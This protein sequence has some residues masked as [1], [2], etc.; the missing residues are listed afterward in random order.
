[1][2]LKRQQ[3][4]EKTTLLAYNSSC[5]LFSIAANSSVSLVTLLLLGASISSGSIF[6]V[7]GFFSFFL[8]LIPCSNM[9]DIRDDNKDKFDSVLHKLLM[10]LPDFLKF[11]KILS[12][13]KSVSDLSCAIELRTEFWS[14]EFFLRFLGACSNEKLF[15]HFV[16]NSS[17]KCHSPKYSTFIPPEYASKVYA[18][19]R[20]IFGICSCA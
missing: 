6:W 5:T 19:L 7:L 14:S 3:H 15:C 1:M 8:C 20:S 11:S 13:E 17:S 18:T 10:V 2:M 12:S 4:I 9:E 16:T